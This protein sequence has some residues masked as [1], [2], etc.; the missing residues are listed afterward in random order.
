MMFP[1]THTALTMEDSTS[2]V[3]IPPPQLEYGVEEKSSSVLLRDEH[4][5]ALAFWVLKKLR[6]RQQFCDIEI[7]LGDA[8]F[9]AHK[10]V[11]AASSSYFLELFYSDRPRGSGEPTNDSEAASNV[12]TFDDAELD[13]SAVEMLLEFI[14]TSVL[15]ITEGSVVS[16]CYAAKFLQMER[17]ERACCKFMANNLTPANCTQRLEY[18]AAQGYDSLEKKCRTFVASNLFKVADTIEFLSLSHASLHAI[19]SADTIKV[20]AKQSLI[21]ILLRWIQHEP[22]S[23]QQHLYA[24]FTSAE[25]AHR[26]PFETDHLPE[27]DRAAKTSIIKAAE[28]TKD[29]APAR[30]PL[31]QDGTQ[32]SSTIFAAGG[33]TKHSVTSS[34]EKYSTATGGWVPARSL[35]KKKSHFALVAVGQSLYSIGGF[36]GR[37]RLSSIDV[38]DI[39][40]D[41]WSTGPS[42]KTPRSGFGAV[43]VNDT[44]HCIGGYD[45]ASHLASTEI[46]DPK[47]TSW[48]EGP[49]LLEK[50]S[51]VQA[52]AVG[53]TVYALGGANGGQSRLQSV[54]MLP[55]GGAAW[56]RVADMN[57]P[58]SRPGVAS[59]DGLLY[60]VG[61]YNGSEHLS[62]VECYHPK[63]DRWEL[64]AS[65]AV[66]RNSPGMAVMSGCLYIA[67]GHDGRKL[68]RS[69]E[70][71]CKETKEWV[72][73]TSMVM[74]RCD[75]GMVAT[76]QAAL[77]TWI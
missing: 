61:G 9:S 51:H 76:G 15:R 59:M 32:T 71:Y 69:V 63:S 68:L 24:L 53:T 12:I 1:C 49:K 28:N 14:Y 19:L 4:Q 72:K 73:D 70:R 16:L 34:I 50:R 42:L 44:I 77:G 74:S 54:E 29:L 6:K 47:A 5:P 60:A 3:K 45:G 27:V 57:I 55:I 48:R 66:P 65:L 18:A 20:S 25:L 13:A 62:S 17:I 39:Q 75:F 23:R 11:L 21:D 7:H 56:S 58:R 33:N 67:G 30:Q 40:T 41:T 46:L 22:S 8:R 31:Q 36:D 35:P 38:Y 43:V 2:A 37:K 26:A 10:V 52:V 64:I